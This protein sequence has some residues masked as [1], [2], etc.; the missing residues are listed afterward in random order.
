MGSGRL[1]VWKSCCFLLV[2]VTQV[3]RGGCSHGC[4]GRGSVFSW[5]TAFSPGIPT[6]ARGT[7][8]GGKWFLEG[9]KKIFL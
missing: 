4:G 5:A 7:L 8:K 1:A 2:P 9:V 6:G 3:L